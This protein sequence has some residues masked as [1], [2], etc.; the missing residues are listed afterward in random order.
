MSPGPPP[1][2]YFTDATTFRAWLQAHAA[3]ATEL[4]VGF[5]KTGRGRATLSWSDSVDEALC[6]GWIDGVRK[7]IDEDRYTIRFTPRKPTSIWS[8]INIA[9]VET[10]RARGRIT[11]AGEA[12]FARRTG[13]KSVVYAHQQAHTAS[14][15][16]PEEKA[17][18]RHRAAW[19]FFDAT[20]PSYR[21]VVLHWIT[22]AKRPETRASRLA[23]LIEACAGRRRPR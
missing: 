7:R 19:A 3:S 23:T 5:H 14:L 9:K 11:A 4:L 17:F 20:P 12:A 8:A 1:A 6:F 18:R 13:P 2:R 21:K 15:S 16:Q 10:L 22:T